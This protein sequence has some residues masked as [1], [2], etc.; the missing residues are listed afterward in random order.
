LPF[1]AVEYRLGG[2]LPLV[3]FVRRED[4]TALLVDASAT[5]SEPRRQG[6]GKMVDDRVGLCPW[7]WA[8]ALPIEWRRVDGAVVEQGSLQI[9][10][11]MCECLLGSC[12]TGKRGPAQRL[13]GFAFLV[14]LLASLLIT[15]T[16]GLRLAMFRGDEDPAWRYPTI[17]RGDDRIAIA[18]REERH[19]LGH[20]QETL[21]H[22]RP[23]ETREPSPWQN[24]CAPDYSASLKLMKR[25]L[26]RWQ[27]ERLFHTFCV[28]EHLGHGF[29][30]NLRI[31]S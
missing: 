3:Q 23:S 24:A 29:S 25:C 10:H 5:V 18:P 20:G 15:R 8:S 4:K 12:C 17:T 19:R 31:L 27:D 11:K 21:S 14:T 22:A 16:L 26:L 1:R 13:A 9:C 30:P 2:S 28:F 7:A 6:S